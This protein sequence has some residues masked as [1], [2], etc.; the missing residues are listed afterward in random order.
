MNEHFTLNILE[1]LLTVLD[2]FLVSYFSASRLFSFSI[3][4]LNFKFNLKSI[5]DWYTGFS[6]EIPE[7]DDLKFKWSGKILL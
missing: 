1:I 5:V 2:F 6:L 4:S 3:S 7:I